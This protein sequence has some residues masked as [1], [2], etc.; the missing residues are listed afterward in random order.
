MRNRFFNLARHL[1][2]VVAKAIAEANANGA[3]SGGYPASRVLYDH[4]GVPTFDRN[5]ARNP[6][7]GL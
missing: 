6:H 1:C 7:F 3:H 5:L 4:S 2:V